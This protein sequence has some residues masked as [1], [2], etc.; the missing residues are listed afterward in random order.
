MRKI[1]KPLRKCLKIL[2][3]KPKILFAFCLRDLFVFL[4]I[5]FCTGLL[6]IITNLQSFAVY[7]DIYQDTSRSLPYSLNI[8]NI[9]I[10]NPRNQVSTDNQIN[11]SQVNKINFPTAKTHPLPEILQK[12]EDKSNSGD[13]FDQVQPTRLGYL[14]WSNFPVKIYIETPTNINQNQAEIWVKTVY[15]T[16][17]EWNSYLPLELV[18]TGEL[19]DIK[20]IRKAPPLQGNPPRA[21]SAQTT[22]EIYTKNNILSHRFTILLSP[23]QTG[24]Y[25]IAASRHELGH[26][27][28]IWG[29]SPL[30]TDVLYFSQVRKPPLI[31]TRDVN[32]LK[33][34]YK[35]P[36]KLGWQVE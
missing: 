20:I 17:K 11:T 36:T 27:L 33:K 12:W 34:V 5:F 10:A 35:Q 30:A 8:L 6:V 32:T 9:A 31:S 14:V 16:V 19:A 1:Q 28:G 21:R 4:G 22:Y 2:D 7:K 3:L 18:N 24:E 29:H 25:L 15:R 26:A 23:T 13:Y